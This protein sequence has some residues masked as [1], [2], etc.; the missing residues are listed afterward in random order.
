MTIR[1]YRDLFAPAV[2]IVL[3]VA[4]MVAVFATGSWV[5]VAA[6]CCCSAATRF[7]RF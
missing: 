1:V 2:L 7:W 3:A 5:A 6:C 4:A